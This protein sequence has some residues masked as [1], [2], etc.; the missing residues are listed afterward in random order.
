[1][2]G[3]HGQAKSI[4]KKTVLK[5]ASP[6]ISTI[7]A[8]GLKRNAV[9]TF[10]VFNYTSGQ[11]IAEVVFNPNELICEIKLIQDNLLPQESSLTGYTFFT[12]QQRLDTKYQR[13]RK[14]FK[15]R[16]R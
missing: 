11:K 10:Q 4:L 15:F 12:N 5:D 16:N 13:K 14:V 6:C 2:M 7:N 8:K 9:V 3:I 1:M